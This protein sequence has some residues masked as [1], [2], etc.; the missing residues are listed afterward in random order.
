[1]SQV[2]SKQ[3]DRITKARVKLLL[4]H[5]FFGNLATRLKIVD[6]SDR[7]PTAA[8]DGRNLYY[9]DSFVASLSD[10]ELIFLIAH[11]V[12]HCV[13]EHML[14][15]GDRDAQVWNMAADYVIN[16]GLVKDKIGEVIKVVPILLDNKYTGKTTDEVYDDLMANAVVIKMPLD[17]HI[18]L[19]EE[20]GDGD[21]E[22]GNGNGSKDGDGKKGGVGKRLTEEERKAL[23]DELKD[24]VIQ[25]AQAA[26]AGNL[27]QGVE[28]LIKDFTDP[29]MPWQDLCRIQLT[30]MI[31]N[32]Y[33]FMRPSRKGWHTGAVLPGMLPAEEVDV[34]IAF[35]TSGSISTQMLKEFLSEVGS[36]MESFDSW[37]I[38]IWCFDTDVYNVQDF[39]SDAGD[40]ITTYEPK[41]GGGTDFMANWNYMRENDI[42]PKQLIVFTDMYPMG[43]WG[44][45]DYCDTLFINHAGN[46]IEAPFGTTAHYTHA[47]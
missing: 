1:M 47:Q 25:A 32:D 8:V 3:R 46:G 36:I 39:S 18:D 7:I 4:H 29:R 6:A 31:K 34:C 21:G 45:P 26:G 28:R 33:S 38:K 12:M 20:D 24:A 16:G 40:D 2:N 41:G 30:S 17:T 19:T 5:P 23:R 42:Q 9:N 35:D 37:T 11:E 10:G 44:E 27:P 15:R 22:D 14:R 43:G 13:Y